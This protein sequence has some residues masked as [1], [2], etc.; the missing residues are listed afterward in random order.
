MGKKNKLEREEEIREA[1]SG[2]D[3]TV[4]TA[5]IDPPAEEI[6]TATQAAI[7]EG[8]GAD[9]LRDYLCSIGKMPPGQSAGESAVALIQLQ[10]R[11]IEWC[12]SRESLYKRAA[13]DLIQIGLDAFYKHCRDVDARLLAGRV[14]IIRESTE[15]SEPPVNVSVEPFVSESVAGT[16]YK[17]RVAYDAFVASQTE[18][19]FPAWDEL[20]EETK[21]LY[22]ESLHHVVSGNEPRT[23]FDRTVA[24]LLAKASE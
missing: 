11:Q 20:P 7:E 2:P 5:V 3:E 8:R 10:Q 23:D 6:K 9:L 22:V 13:E 17:A 4:N 21:G 1:L 14:E 19:N 12:E 16:I 18:G 15:L 24:R